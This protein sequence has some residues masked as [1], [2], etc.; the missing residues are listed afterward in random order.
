MNIY[1][2]V[3][4]RNRRDTLF[5]KGPVQFGWIRQNIPDATSRLILVVEA[6]M[7]MDKSGSIALT[8]QVWDCA[9]VNDKHQRARV[10]AK[11]DKTV[12]GYVVERRKGRTALIHRATTAGEKHK[13]IRR[14]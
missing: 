9:G 5:L 6:F 4:Q 3:D 10:L 13:P 8:R 14:A 7:V 1:S 12:P 2:A 11:I